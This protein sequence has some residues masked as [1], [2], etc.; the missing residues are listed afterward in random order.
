MF[1]I[2]LIFSIILLAASLFYLGHQFSLSKPEVIRPY[3]TPEP[4]ATQI[5]VPTIQNQTANW[6]T[7]QVLDPQDRPLGILY[8]LPP[9]IIRKPS[10][11]NA[12]HY[13]K[14]AILPGNSSLAV[15]PIG[16]N[17]SYQYGWDELIVKVV[18]QNNFP[19]KQ[20][21]L[22]GGFPGVNFSGT[23]TEA[24][25]ANIN[26]LGV[27]KGKF[28]GQLVKI[29][30]DLFLEIVLYQDK[31][32]ANFGKVQINF[33]ADEPLFDQIL[34]TFKFTAQTQNV[35]T[36]TVSLP[37][38]KLETSFGIDGNSTP[39]YPKSTSV[40]FPSVYKSKI[41]AYGA[42]YEVIIGPNNWGGKGGV[43]A[44]GN[45]S[46]T[47]YPVNGSPDKGPRIFVFIA[48]T[49]TGAALYEA[50]PYFPWIGANKPEIGRVVKS[51][52]GL[53]TAFVTPHL[54][55][56]SLPGN[57]PNSETI[58]VAYSDA[59]DQDQNGMW[60]F[61]K[62]EVIFPKKDHDFGKALLDLFVQQKNLRN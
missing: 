22:S 15:I 47:L 21:V 40:S 4:F 24:T 44:D 50:A 31:A 62:M 41:A 3:P 9:E 33:S 10:W 46:I 29:N 14:N 2:A 1:K 49:G 53:K 6:E 35:Q 5:P 8:K 18:T 19:Q 26:I 55:E 11:V 34:A 56:Y 59:Q 13:Y 7:Y 61:S 37:V 42:S 17:L 54:V 16:E 45:R 30:N 43:G 38:T 58:G 25:T 51:P 39:T 57:D 60:A 20:T 36:E 27:G 28:R 23:L 32:Y 52:E 48:S 12:G